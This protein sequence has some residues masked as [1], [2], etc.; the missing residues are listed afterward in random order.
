MIDEW[1][2]VES[3]VW[4]PEE[5]EEISGIYLG[6]Q[7]EVGMNASN[8]YKIEC[9][10]KTLSVWGSKVLDDAMLSVKE[11]QE[12]KIKFM[13]KIK[14]EKGKEYKSYEV[15]TRDLQEQPLTEL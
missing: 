13:G 11:G 14:P 15:F 10:E 5:G 3:E 1:T 8:L 7:K 9:G 12:V 6:V 4:K 2:K